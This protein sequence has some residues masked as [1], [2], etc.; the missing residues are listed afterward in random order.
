MPMS[1]F[2]LFGHGPSTVSLLELYH[3]MLACLLGFFVAHWE[4][5]N[6][7]SLFLPWTYDASQLV[8]SAS[9]NIVANNRD[10]FK[11]KLIWYFKRSCER[12][13][14]I[15]CQRVAENV[16][17]EVTGQLFHS[18]HAFFTI[19]YVNVQLQYLKNCG[20]GYCA[21]TK[22]KVDSHIIFSISFYRLLH[23][24]TS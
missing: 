23:S 16:P 7:G 19:Q 11:T 12:H 20:Y 22:L 3:I 2:S 18:F 10:L 4:K 8:S 5:Y 6:T 1:L 13:L 9:N 24:F 21:L 15:R 14:A 17:A